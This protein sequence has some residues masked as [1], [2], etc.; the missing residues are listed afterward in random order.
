VIWRFPRK[1][2][3]LAKRRVS[4]ARRALALL[5]CGVLTGTAIAAV[6]AAEPS[7]YAEGCQQR[8]GS[9]SVGNWPPACWRPYGNSSPFNRPIP[10]NPRLASESAASSSYILSNRWY[11]SSDDHGNFVTDSGGSR[12]VYWSRSSDP[13]VTVI[14]RGG[15]SC[16]R[17]I[18]VRIP[19]GAQPQNRSD[20]HMAVIDQAHRLEYDFWRAST[21]SN[22]E[23]TVSAASRIP[24]GGGSATGLGGR[25]EAAR[26][27]LLGGLLR[28]PELAAGRIDHALAIT[29]P[30]V[31][32]SDVWPAPARG[33]GDHVCARN[34]PGPHLGSLLQLNMSDAAIAATHAP[35]WQAAIMRAM[36]HYGMYVVDTNGRGNREM[37]LIQEDDKS[38]TS[39]GYPGQM[40][41]FIRS[42]GGR[43]SVA[44]VPIDQSR[45]R[46]I[47]PCVPRGTC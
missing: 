41:S 13:L 26:L 28:A 19:L 12:P 42:I 4:A 10:A 35:P 11:F 24:I 15:Y 33:R 46:V 3:L 18:K 44:G 17:G 23:M 31:Q 20:G 8:F 34:G 21:P 36:A 25:G 9:F 7:V 43:S 47:D 2:R 14:C 5:T 38:F 27:G 39:F 40:S 37:S 6:R 16:Q 30:C 1:A 45:L 29:A 32:R 22:G